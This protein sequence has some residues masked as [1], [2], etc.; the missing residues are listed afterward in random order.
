LNFIYLISRE[1]SAKILQK[2]IN[3]KSIKFKKKLVFYTDERYI[4]KL[5]LL[6]NEKKKN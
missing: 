3:D 4:K 2:L 6:K 1:W 5:K